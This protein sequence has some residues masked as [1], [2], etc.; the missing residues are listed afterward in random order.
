MFPAR[1]DNH[2]PLFEAGMSLY[3]FMGMLGVGGFLIVELLKF[4][5]AVKEIEEEQEGRQ[6]WGAQGWDGQLIIIK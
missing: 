2:P 1:V 4:L 5:I 6:D 3:E